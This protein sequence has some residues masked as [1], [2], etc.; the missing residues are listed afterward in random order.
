LLSGYLLK[1][2]WKKK[3][4]VRQFFYRE[5]TRRKAKAFE[6]KDVFVIKAGRTEKGKRGERKK[7]KAV[8]QRLD[9]QRNTL[10]TRKFLYL[11]CSFSY[12]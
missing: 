7:R 6:N 3:K 10:K 9:G 11:K 4:T 12:V 1:N 5:G 2:P 8:R